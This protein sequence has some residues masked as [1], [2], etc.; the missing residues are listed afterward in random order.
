[1]EMEAT[2]TGAENRAKRR[3]E[4][5]HG[6]CR[7]GEPNRCRLGYGRLPQNRIGRAAGAAVVA[8]AL[9][10]NHSIGAPE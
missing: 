4:E 9:L 8:V 5:D 1:M 10:A 6:R 2:T 3:L 7:L